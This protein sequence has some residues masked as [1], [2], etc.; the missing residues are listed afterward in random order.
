MRQVTD[1]LFQSGPKALFLQIVLVVIVVGAFRFCRRHRKVKRVENRLIRSR[2]SSCVVCRSCVQLHPKT[3]KTAGPYFHSEQVRA[4]SVR[5]FDAIARSTHHPSITHGDTVQLIGR[6]S[7]VKV[8][9]SGRWLGSITANRGVM[10][11]PDLM[12]C[13]F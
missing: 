4:A 8:L 1:F 7:A 3:R 9:S 11:R 13:R 10:V 5:H 6:P 2:L 12:G